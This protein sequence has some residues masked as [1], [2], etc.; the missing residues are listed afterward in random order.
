MSGELSD[1][2]IESVHVAAVAN[3]SSAHALHDLAQ[4]E[5][6]AIVVVG[7]THTG[8]A[9]GGAGAAEVALAAR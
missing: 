9:G 8:R 7:S 2:T 1:V 4:A 5:R 6:A 3:S